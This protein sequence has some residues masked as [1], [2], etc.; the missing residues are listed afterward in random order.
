MIYRNQ[1]AIIKVIVKAIRAAID[2]DYHIMVKAGYAEII[3]H[4]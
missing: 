2:S 1:F 3:M 4:L